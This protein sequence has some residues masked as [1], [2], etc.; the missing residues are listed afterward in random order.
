M[1]V[2]F[3]IPTLALRGG[4]ENVTI[5]KANALSEIE[6]MEVAIAFAD[7]LGYKETIIRPLA[8]KVKAIDLKAPFWD[9]NSISALGYLKKLNRLRRAL[10]S[11]IDTW[12]PD[13]VVSTGLMDRYVF[14]FLKQTTP[15]YVKVLEYH[16]ASNYKLIEAEATTGKAGLFRRL[17][18]WFDWKVLSRAYDFNALLTSQDYEENAPADDDRY[19]YVYNPSTL[20]L[21]DNYPDT[22]RKKIILAAGRL[23]TQKGFESLL[24]IWKR[25]D[26]KDGW[27]LKIVGDGELYDKLVK[28]IAEF[29][30][31]DSVDLPGFISD[32]RS[33]MKNA[34]IFAVSSIWEGF[35]LVLVEALSSGC[36][37]ISYRTPYGPADIL[38]GSGAGVLVD[39]GDEEGFARELERLMHSLETREEMSIKARRRARHFMP[40]KIIADWI[41]QYNKLL[42]RKRR[43]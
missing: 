2:L 16:F 30:L 43:H 37:A 41:E 26:N 33:E 24:R 36:P 14:P 28:L 25:I 1:K 29:G 22:P 20:T 13:I 4:M 39:M 6:G 32:V 18:H 8:P 5:L 38:E 31:E 27:K 12:R 23:T 40:D 9:S 3:Y 11:F 42:T 19:G 34:S 21:E 17:Q 10:Q 7:D 35:S 15:G